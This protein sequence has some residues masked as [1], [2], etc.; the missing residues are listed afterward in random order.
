MAGVWTQEEDDILYRGEAL[1]IEALDTKHGY[2]ASGDRRLFLQVWTKTALDLR[3]R[4][5]IKWRR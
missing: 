5:K 2:G 1:A 4:E 3:V